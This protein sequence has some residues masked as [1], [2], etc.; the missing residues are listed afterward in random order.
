M[1]FRGAGGVG[2]E[3]R[4]RPAFTNR[5][6]QTFV[7]TSQTLVQT[8]SWRVRTFNRAMTVQQ[9]RYDRYLETHM[10]KNP[11]PL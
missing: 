2:W 7:G 11:E 8:S 9:L 4:T 3:G 6:I 5:A 10:W 1:C